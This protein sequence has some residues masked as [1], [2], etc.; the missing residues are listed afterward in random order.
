MPGE[1]KESTPYNG[2]NGEA[3]YTLNLVYSTNSQTD[4]IHTICDTWAGC[5]AG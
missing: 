4:Y 2:L 1:S 5:T 3:P